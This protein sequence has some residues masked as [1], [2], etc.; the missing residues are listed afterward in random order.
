MTNAKSHAEKRGLL[1]GAGYFSDFH[2]DA[3]K[4]INGATIVCICDLDEAKAKQA[5]EKYGIADIC[6]DVSAALQRTDIDFVDLATGPAARLPIV[7]R[8]LDRGLPMICQKPVAENFAEAKKILDVAE[9]SG[10]PFMVHENFRFQPW[11]REIK[12]LLDSGVIGHQLHSIHM[13]TRMGDGWGDDAYLGRQ[14]YFRSMPRLLVHETGVHFVDTFRFLAGEIAQC[15]AELQQ[16]NPVIAG[17]DA[18]VLHFRFAN[19]G[20]ATW[21]ASRYHESLADEPRYTFGEMTVESDKGSLWLDVAGKI[22]VKPLG[23][24]AYV[25]DYKHSKIGF[26]GDC[27]RLCQEHFLE[28]INGNAVCETRPAEYT[29]T[30]QVVEAAYESARL[31][32]TVSLTNPTRNSE[33]SQRRVVDLSLVV[34]NDMSGVEITTAKRLEVEG[35][36]ATTLSL[37]SHAGT[38]MDAPRHFLTDGNTLDQQTLAVCCGSARVVNLAGT[39]PRHAIS[40]DDVTQALADVYPGDRLLF[41]TDWHEQFGTPE[42]RDALPRI[43]IELAHWLVEKQVAMIGVEPPSVADVNNREE[44]TEVHQVLFRGGVLIVEGLA[45]LNELTQPVV[46]FIALPL[47]ILG[48]DGCPVRAIAIE[49]SPSRFANSHEVKS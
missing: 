11:H 16:F 22:T 3:W 29:K 28:V 38:H 37:Y 24:S 19:G 25:H 47:R 42:Y 41:R 36:N 30:L 18:A 10:V 5:A 4:R 40:V 23:E 21:D 9:K 26:A 1:I 17:E 20:K 14:P 12:R 8:V 13:R 44:L 6:T 45:N 27:V 39:Q 35:W 34:S 31:G 7:E 2:L 32:Q 48:G 33:H 46:E 15:D 49:Y 43:S